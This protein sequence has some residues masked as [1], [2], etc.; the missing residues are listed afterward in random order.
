M[1]YQQLSNTGNEDYRHLWVQR[2]LTEARRE[3]RD[4]SLLDVGAGPAPYREFAQGLG[5]GYRSQDFSQYV[6]S[7]TSPGLQNEAWDYPQHS[8]VCDITEIPDE[9]TS[10]V[11]LCTEVLEHVPDPVRAFERMAHLLIPGGRLIVSVPMIS[12]MHQ[13]PYWFQSGLSPFWFE[14][15][16]AKSDLSVEHL[17]VYGDYVDLMSQEVDRLL[18]FRPRIK[19]LNRIGSRAV[20][21]LRPLLPQPVLQSGG[22]GTLFIGVKEVRGSI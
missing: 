18:A 5:F 22:F 3:Y 1:A 13:A 4:P 11:I 9:A 15:W 14:H 19:G 12:L 2:T 6:P 17:S 21:L 16:A 10:D 20:R 7:E 8:F